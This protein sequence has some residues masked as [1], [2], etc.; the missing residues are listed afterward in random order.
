MK[1]I[2]KEDMLILVP[3][4]EHE[5]LELAQWESRFEQHEFVLAKNPG[6]G[7]MLRDLGD[8]RLSQPINVTSKHPSPS[9]QLIGN[10]GATPFELDGIS[11]ASVESFWQSLKCRKDNDRLRI[12]KLSGAEAKRASGAFPYEETFT[13]R[14]EEILTGSFSHWKLMARACAAKFDQNA[15]ARSALVSTFPYPLEHRLR[16]DSQTIPGDVMAR[17]WMGFRHQYRQSSE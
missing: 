3:N 10:F 5:T 1:A 4:G 11:Y 9:I 15:A 12:A 14:G 13:Y 17:I 7:V 2:F 6:C 16:N 8:P